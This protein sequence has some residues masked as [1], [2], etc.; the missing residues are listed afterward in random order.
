[1]AQ[2]HLAQASPGLHAERFIAMV[3]AHLNPFAEYRVGVGRQ[4]QVD[5]E[6][7]RQ[8]LEPIGVAGACG[9]RAA[10]ISFRD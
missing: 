7:P 4:R 5:D 3:E 6:Y 10:T 2:E 8:G 9:N 1:M